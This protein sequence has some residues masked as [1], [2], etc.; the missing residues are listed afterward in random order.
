MNPWLRVAGLF[1]AVVVA[2]LVLKALPPLLVLALI[3]AGV[4]Y[5]HHVLITKPK[6]ERARAAAEA[7]GFR[8]VPEGE[9]GLLGLPFALLARP[10]VVTSE[11]MVG[12]WRGTEVRLFDLELPRPGVAAGAGRFTCA[13]APL[14]F[15][16]PHLVVEPLAFLTPEEERPDM[17]ACAAPSERVAAAFDVRCEDPAFAASVLD[18]PV[19]GWLLGEGERIGFE[20]AGRA[21]LLYQPWVPPRERDALLEALSGFLA[22]VPASEGR[23]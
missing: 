18:G 14:P 12:P 1:A 23:R 11:V 16:S 19:V 4:G 7:L 17:P 2:A 5:A 6:R 21:A 8:S 20:L 9:T 15:S 22:A 10:G 13:L 3:V